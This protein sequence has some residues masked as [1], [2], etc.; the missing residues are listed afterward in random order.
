MN[1]T[2]DINIANQIFH[3]D[4]SA[5]RILKNYLDAIKTSLAN[6]KSR[7]EIIQDIEARI[8]E[9]F[10]ERMIS[11]KQV[12]NIEDVN[13]VIKIMGQPED[14]NIADDD[15]DTQSKTHKKTEKKLFRDKSQSYIS[16]VCAGLS[17]YINVEVVWIRLVWILLTVF[18]SGWFILI[19][20]ILWALIP[21]AKTTAEKLSMKGEPITLS[22]IEK[23]IKEGYDNVSEKL[24]D[25]DVKKHSENAQN[26]ISKFFSVLEQI[27]INLGKVLVKIIG[28]ILLIF[29]GIGLLALI[30][31]TL[32]VSGIGLF[33]NI[34]LVESGL[35]RLD[36]IVITDFPAWVVILSTFLAIGIPLLFIFIF[37]LKMLFTNIKSIGTAFS[38]S[39]VMLWLVSI[40]FIIFISISTSLKDK[41]AGEIVNTTALNLK[42]KDTL[43][44]K[45]NANLNY[46]VFPFKQNQQKI[47]YVE[48]DDKQVLYD[49]N[50]DVKFNHI[51]DDRA[52]IRISK[53]TYDFEESTARNKASLI[54]YDYEINENSFIFDSYMLAPKDLKNNSIGIDIDIYLPEDVL[55]SLD[56]STDDFIE[57][58]FNANESENPYKEYF[59]L[60][61]NRLFCE[62]CE[63]KSEPT[64]NLN[65]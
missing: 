54:K 6:E 14:F 8:A 15:D 4:E 23:K 28:F 20:I 59:I 37:S 55:I 42:P 12:I 46:T 5:Y 10:I 7:D 18:S 2:L 33:S 21:E 26:S 49:S 35:V 47:T 11:D 17:H 22:N 32:G 53:W 16:G 36:G 25:V 9:L 44:L 31:S 52:F 3:I 56:E 38:I 27:V 64:G 61:E 41:T 51:S 39:M 30:I 50:I 13:E 58:Y 1:K 62:S 19:Y 63:E 34:D 65:E 48:N 40:A 57:N 43:Y 29:S 24:K 45:M 60:K